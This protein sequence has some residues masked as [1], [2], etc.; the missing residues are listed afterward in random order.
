MARLDPLD[1]SHLPGL[2]D[3]SDRSHHL[4]LLDLLRLPGLMD[5]SF[6][7]DPERHCTPARRH[8]LASSPARHPSD[9]HHPRRRR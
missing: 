9:T 3:P 6:P 1:P 8:R 5:R 4:A 7:L 2:L